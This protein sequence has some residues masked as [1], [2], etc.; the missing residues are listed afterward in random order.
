MAAGI[1]ATTGATGVI[2]ATGIIGVTA[3]IGVTG[4]TGTIGNRNA[5]TSAAGHEARRREPKFA[6]K[7]SA[8]F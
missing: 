2:G 3:A 4:A 1:T 6:N 7:I 5:Q 8:F